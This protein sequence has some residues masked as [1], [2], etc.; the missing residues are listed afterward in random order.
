M[1]LNP[2]LSCLLYIFFLQRIHT[3]SSPHFCRFL[4]IAVAAGN[5]QSLFA[6]NWVLVQFS[7]EFSR[8]H[9]TQNSYLVTVAI[10][11]I[12]CGSGSTSVQRIV[13]N[14]HQQQLQHHASKFMEDKTGIT[15]IAL[16]LQSLHLSLLFMDHLHYFSQFSFSLVGIFPL[17][18]LGLWFFWV[19]AILKDHSAPFFFP[20]WVPIFLSLVQ[21]R[22]GCFFFFPGWVFL[23]FV[24]CG[25]WVLAIL[26]KNCN[27]QDDCQ[28][29]KMGLISSS[30]SW[31]L[32]QNKQDL[33]ILLV[34]HSGAH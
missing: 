8:V 24:L 32:L 29:A 34:D 9:H 21:Y 27:K 1:N 11:F 12:L 33:G 20:H 26:E 4:I 13:D 5:Q 2:I 7:N 28:L 17:F 22:F 18:F 14:S 15:I 19:L 23:W 31:I 6:A 30:L 25:F 3:I 10:E 16:S